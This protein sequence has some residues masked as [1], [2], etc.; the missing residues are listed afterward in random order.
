MFIFP[1]IYS[2]SEGY[3][4]KLQ[5]VQNSLARKFFVTKTIKFHFLAEQT[6][7]KNPAALLDQ[8]HWLPIFPRINFKIATLT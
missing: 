3:I 7:N 5:R 1:T 2:Q 6:P 8:L 4:K